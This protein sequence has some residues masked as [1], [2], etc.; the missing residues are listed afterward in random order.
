M[1]P[2]FDLFWARIYTFGIALTLCFFAFLWNLRR[3]E[4][5][6]WY[7]FTFFSH[8]IL[9]YFT[10]VFFFSRVFYVIGRWNDM[11]FIKDPFQFFMM[12]DYN[13][14]LFWAIFWFLVVLLILSRIERTPISRYIDWV[15]LAFIWALCV[16]YIGS[17]FGGQVYGRETM[18]GIEITYQNVAFASVPYKVPVFPL[19]IVYTLLSFFLFS[20]L[21]ILS[22]FI[23]I[24]GFIWY[25]GL[26]IFSSM[27]LIFEFFSGKPDILSVSTAFNL[28]QFFALFLS[29][30]S[31]YQ[32]YKIFKNESNVSENNNI[33]PQ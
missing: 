13:F 4:K 10:S 28:P 7:S 18:F 26:I 32:L 6:F 12:S 3:L 5:R 27:I 11:K 1:Y 29:I 21:Y 2:F 9:W 24:R 16:G 25:L 23:H 30:G 20:G 19:P 15:V 17:F 33:A 22:L 31:W 14:S 8:N